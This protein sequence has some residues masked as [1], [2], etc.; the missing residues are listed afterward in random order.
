MKKVVATIGSGLALTPFLALAQSFDPNG[1]IASIITS[2]SGWINVLIGILVTL[3]V[4]VFIWGL[5]TY[6]LNASNEEKRSDSKWYMIYGIVILFVM[7]SIWGLVGL[8]QNI[9]GAESNVDAGGID[10]PTVTGTDIQ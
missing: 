6:L 9:T 7:V 3:A 5:I 10:I 1:Y 4:L 8:L 2:F